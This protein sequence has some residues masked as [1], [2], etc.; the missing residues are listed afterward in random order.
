MVCPAAANGAPDCQASSDKLCQSK[1]FK[2]GKSLDTDSVQACSAAAL[3]SGGNRQAGNRRTN[4]YA[5][6]ALCE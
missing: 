5:T 1:G 4:Y 3:L 6:C 2:Q